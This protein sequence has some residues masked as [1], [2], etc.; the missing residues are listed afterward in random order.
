MSGSEFS[1][2]D[3]EQLADDRQPE[4]A[5]GAE[6][7][8][9]YRVDHEAEHNRSRRGLAT[10][11]RIRWSLGEKEIIATRKRAIGVGLLAIAGGLHDIV[12]H[13]AEQLVDL[14]AWSFEFL[15]QSRREGGITISPTQFDDM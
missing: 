7:G 3:T 8:N 4:P 1:E 9:T 11:A 10:T 2:A 13:Q 12:M 14:D 5:A 6:A 15:E